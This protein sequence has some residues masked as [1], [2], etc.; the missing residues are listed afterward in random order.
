M[1]TIL[2]P[3]QNFDHLDGLPLLGALAI[4]LSLSSGYGI[5]ALVRWPNDVVCLGRKLAGTLVEAKFSGNR[6]TYALLGIGLNVNFQASEITNEA[7]SATTVLDILGHAVDMAELVC[8]ILLEVERLCD[9]LDSGLTVQILEQLRKCEASRGSRI[10]INLEDRRVD[11]IFEDYETLTRVR[12]LDSQGKD[13]G[14]DT[15]SVV[16]VEYLGV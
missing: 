11:G 12:M 9:E 2:R 13:V 6:P 5:K 4:A 10:I 8:S 16:T 15:G 14:I 1:T 7:E 3:V